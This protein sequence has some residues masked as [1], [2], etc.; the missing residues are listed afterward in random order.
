M[1]LK[2]LVIFLAERMKWGMP[3]QAEEGEVGWMRLRLNWIREQWV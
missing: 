1:W 3:F 2:W